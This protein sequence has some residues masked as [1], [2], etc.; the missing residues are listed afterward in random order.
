MKK[1]L[2]KT[3]GGGERG[4]GFLNFGKKGGRGGGGKKEGEKERRGLDGFGGFGTALVYPPIL[5]N[6]A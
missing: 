3:F 5:H 4:G 2:K 1:E 6:L